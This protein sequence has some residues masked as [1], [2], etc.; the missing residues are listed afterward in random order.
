[1]KRF[2]VYDDNGNYTRPHDI[3]DLKVLLIDEMEEETLQWHED[4]NSVIKSNFEIIRQLVL[5]DNISVD[6]LITQLNS[7][8]WYILDLCK[9]QRDLSNYQAFKHGT[10]IPCGCIPKDCIEETLQMIDKDMENV[11]M[12]KSLK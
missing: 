6:Y 10:G 2:I 5:K 11:I 8:G 12:G 1:M 4:D 3:K 9:L 7:F